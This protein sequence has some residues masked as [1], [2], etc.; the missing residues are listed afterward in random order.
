MAEAFIARS[1]FF[2]HIPVKEALKNRIN[3][4][5]AIRNGRL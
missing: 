3:M 5:G 2:S 1:K 4:T